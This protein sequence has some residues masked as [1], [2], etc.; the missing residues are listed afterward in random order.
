MDHELDPGPGVFEV[1]E[2]VPGLLNDPR[3]D[4]VP[5]CAEDPDSAGAA[6]DGRQA[7]ITRPSLT[8]IKHQVSDRD[9]VSGTHTS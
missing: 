9:R 3:L 4:R 5:G 1:H 6:L 2:Q 7:Q 8:G